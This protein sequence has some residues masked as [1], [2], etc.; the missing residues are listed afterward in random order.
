MSDQERVAGFGQR[1]RENSEGSGESNGH[2]PGAGGEARVFLQPIA[3]PSVLGLFGFAAATFMVSANLAGWYG[4]NSTQEYLAPFAAMFGGVAQFL[5]GM[6]AYKARDAIATAMHGMWG[7]FW[8]AYGILF[9]LISTGTLSATGVNFSL[10]VGYWFAMLSA[11]TLMGAIAALGE[12]V[13]LATV[14]NTLW[15]GA[16]CLAVGF[17]TTTH[18]WVVIGAYVL[19]LSALCAWYT[20]GALMFEG[21]GRPIL[22]VGKTRKTVEKAGLSVGTGEPGVQ[23]G[24]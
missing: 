15:V 13:A 20:A 5:A 10:G 6:W 3:A 22:P 23:H 1:L 21:A 11:I 14:L 12:N 24:Q 16:G 8:I 18:F 17:L 19:L 4:S 2:R 7:A 9:L